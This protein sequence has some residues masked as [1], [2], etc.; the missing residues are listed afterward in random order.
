MKGEESVVKFIVQKYTFEDVEF[1]TCEAALYNRLNII[2]YLATKNLFYYHSVVFT[3]AL[4]G[5]MEI[6]V[7]FVDELNYP[8]F[9]RIAGGAARGGFINILDYAIIKG[10]NEYNEMLRFVARSFRRDIIMYLVDKCS[11]DFNIISYYVS[12]EVVKYALQNCAN[13]I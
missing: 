1:I 6:V 12:L 4:H 9:E 2:K 8:D 3:A 10:V 7:Y 13:F 11:N 5:N